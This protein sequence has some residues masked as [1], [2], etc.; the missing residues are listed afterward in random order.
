MGR[1]ERRKGHDFER[2]VAAMLRPVFPGAA[3]GYQT[4]GGTGEAPDV[5]GTPFYIECKKQRSQPSIAN[6]MTQA[7]D[8]SDGRVPLAI[9]CKDRQEPIVSMYLKDFLALCEKFYGRLVEEIDA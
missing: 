9:T 3:R 4:R 6:A 5:D 8:G 1:A 2:A 7:A